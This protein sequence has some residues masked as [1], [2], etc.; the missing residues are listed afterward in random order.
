LAALEAR[1]LIGVWHLPSCTHPWPDAGLG[2]QVWQ[3]WKTETANSRTLS[4]N[5][6][7]RSDGSEPS[8]PAPKPG[9]REHVFPP[10]GPAD[11]MVC[12]LLRWWLLLPLCVSRCGGIRTF[13]FL[14]SC[15]VLPCC[16]S[17]VCVALSTF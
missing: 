6:R 10:H 1:T 3:S 9:G 17:G 14:C 5:S 4:W 8:P 16:R 2:M 13:L 12:R 11:G 7:Q 15:V